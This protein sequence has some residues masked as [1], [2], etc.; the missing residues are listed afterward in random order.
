MQ[1]TITIIKKKYKNIYTVDKIKILHVENINNM[2]F[3]Y[4]K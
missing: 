3:Y 4:Q 2:L 1:L